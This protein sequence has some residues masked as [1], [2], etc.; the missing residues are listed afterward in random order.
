MVAADEVAFRLEEARRRVAERDRLRERVEST[1]AARDEARRAADASAAELVEQQAG[2]TRLETMSPTRIWAA[3]T[4]QRDSALARERAERDRASYLAAE[5]HGRLA[6]LDADLSRLNQQLSAYRAVDDELEAAL[7]AKEELLAATGARSGAELAGIAEER[8]TLSARLKELH[9]AAV[10]A[11]D[12]RRALAD[13]DRLLGSARNWS[14]WDTF[15]GGGLFTDMVKYDRIDEATR[16][17]G[18]AQRALAALERE[19]ADIGSQAALKL[20]ASLGAKLFDTLFDNIFSDLAMRSRIVDAHDTVRRVLPRVVE[21]LPPIDEEMR[22]VEAQVAAL[23][24]RRTTI[25]GELL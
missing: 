2:V 19:L 23:D 16:A 11:V 10:A 20:E 5:A 25:L 7:M 1:L 6:A 21:L 17:I 12:A 9:E 22:A 24:S 4:L 13:A 3:L 14:N 8:G 15:M 18:A